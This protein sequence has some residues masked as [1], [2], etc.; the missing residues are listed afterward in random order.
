MRDEAFLRVGDEDRRLSFEQ[1]VELRY[2]RGDTTFVA[3]T[4]QAAILDEDS[5]ADYAQRVGHPDRQRLLQARDLIAPV[6]NC[7]SVPVRNVCI[8]K[9]TSGCSGTLEKSAAPVPHRI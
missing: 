3:R 7:C 4:Y 5:V 9:P 1:R 8:L 2:D 6:G